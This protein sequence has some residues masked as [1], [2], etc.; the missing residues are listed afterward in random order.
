MADPPPRDSKRGF[1]GAEDVDD[2]PAFAYRDADG[3]RYRPEDGPPVQ[4]A[5]TA[6]L[7]RGRSTTMTPGEGRGVLEVFVCTSESA[8]ATGILLVDGEPVGAGDGHYQV[9]ISAGA[10]TLGVQGAD[11]A[12]A[13]F[14][15]APGER[16]RYTTGQG[17]AVRNQLDFRTQL[18]RLKDG[19]DLMP[20]FGRSQGNAANGGCLLAVSGGVVL[21]GALLWAVLAPEGT[22]QA[23]AAIA[24]LV[25]VAML[26]GGAALGI[27]TTRRLHKRA[28]AARVEPVHRTS[29]GGPVAFPAPV[30][31]RSW[32]GARRGVAIVFDLYLYRVTRRP[33]GR[34]VY[35]GRGEPL[36]TAHAGGLRCWIDG[37]RTE[38]DWSTWFYP[39]AASEHRFRIE[40]G[41]DPLDGSEA[42]HEFTFKVKNVD[43]IAVLHVP[44]RVFR[45]W[46]ET[47]QRL[48]GFPPQ[49]R[50]RVSKL[51]RPAGGLGGAPVEQQDDWTPPRVWAWD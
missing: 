21:A 12:S 40:Y 23:V 34:A 43:D 47:A 37:V 3:R 17:V 33:D 25:G 31:L 26:V 9:E 22:T 10:H 28:K 4:F 15:L 20:V 38:C 44:V 39:L 7:R 32:R 45:I 1:G 11:A 16:I 42:A 35:S 6:D 49:V 18:Y 41:P 27:G 2:A 50:H 30:D 13:A 14:S 48:T 51:A 29:V 8:D 5:S 36:A 24:V 19:H 46:D